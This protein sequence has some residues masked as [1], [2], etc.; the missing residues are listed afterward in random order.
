MNTR[1]RLQRTA[2]LAAIVA[3]SIGFAACGSDDD[4]GS[5]GTSA[6][7]ATDAA[8]PAG[9]DASSGTAAEAPADCDVVSGAVS[10]RSRQPDHDR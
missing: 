10:L 5:D 3:V 9:T 1:K 8:E 4:S 2:A 6:P 7:A